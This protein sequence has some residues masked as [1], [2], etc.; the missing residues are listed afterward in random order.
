M[1]IMMTQN[2]TTI[3]MMEDRIIISTHPEELWAIG[4][5]LGITEG[6]GQNKRLFKFLVALRAVNRGYNFYEIMTFMG[7]DYHDP[8][9]RKRFRSFYNRMKIWVVKNGDNLPGLIFDINVILKKLYGNHIIQV[10][11][12][13]RYTAFHF[14]NGESWDRLYVDHRKGNVG[15]PITTGRGSNTPDERGEGQ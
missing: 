1:M 12:K 7:L 13:E 3:N 9:T 11:Q 2:Y 14:K 10:E 4:R 5:T 8:K 6:N 15:R